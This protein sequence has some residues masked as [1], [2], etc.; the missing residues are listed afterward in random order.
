MLKGSPDETGVVEPGGLEE[1]SVTWGAHRLRGWLSGMRSRRKEADL[2]HRALR[3]LDRGDGRIEE[4]KFGGDSHYRPLNGCA[5]LYFQVPLELLGTPLYVEIEYLGDAHGRFAL[6]YPS[7]LKTGLE[8]DYLEAR[9]HWSGNAGELHL[10]RCRY[11]LEDFDPSKTQN[12]G[13]HFR[14]YHPSDDWI[15][16]VRVSPEPWPEMDGF[17]FSLERAEPRKSPGRF[18]KIQWLFLE[19]TNLCNFSCTFCPDEIM[20]RRRGW[21]KTAD[22]L[23]LLDQIAEHR[24]WLGPVHPIKLHQMGE[25]MIH[26]DIVPIV[27]HAERLGLGVELNTN[28]SLLKSS[29]V[30]GLYKAGLNSFVL[31]YLNHTPQAFGTRKVKNKKLTF[32]EYRA[33]VEAAIETKFRLGSETRIQLHLAN[34]SAAAAFPQLISGESEARAELESW[35][36]FGR[37]LEQEVGLEPSGLDA[38]R[39]LEGGILDRDELGSCVELLPGVSLLW[40]RIHSWGHA[41]PG[42][43]KEPGPAYCVVP[44]EQ[45]VI[46]H[47]GDI[48]VCCTDF[49]GGLVVGNLF[50]EGIEKIWR[51]KRLLELRREMFAGRL[52]NPVCRKCRGWD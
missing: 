42:E 23:A 10:R 38:R 26:R 1:M 39:I 32:Q 30:E 14:L 43:A 37:R 3:I 8:G 40:K 18:H 6:Q 49:D 44:Y 7:S 35:L 31:S 29:L 51:G 2:R 25:P 47:N 20:T 36:E 50:E 4:R 41:L 11:F 34:A 48:S 27:A 46:Q 52:S 19:L 21:M 5:Y 28:A 16:D 45:F 33:G 22:V 17:P 9:Q 12:Y 15:R 13:A 24:E